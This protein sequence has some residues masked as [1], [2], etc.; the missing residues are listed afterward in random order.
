LRH[1]ENGNKVDDVKEGGMIKGLKKRSSEGEKNEK[2]WGDS[3][4]WCKI[5]HIQFF[6]K[7]LS[8]SNVRLVLLEEISGMMKITL[9]RAAPDFPFITCHCFPRKFRLFNSRNHSHMLCM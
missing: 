9:P 3:F 6:L 4:T 1:R 8:F 7:T 2:F 5:T